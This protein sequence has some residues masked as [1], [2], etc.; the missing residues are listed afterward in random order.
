[1]ANCTARTGNRY[2]TNTRGA[3]MRMIVTYS[4]PQE[5]GNELVKTGKIGEVLEKIVEDFSPEA[6]YFYLDDQ[7]RRA[8]VFVVNMDDP[9]DL[10]RHVE[11]LSIGLNVSVTARPAFSLEDMAGLGDVVGPV[12]Q[13][14]G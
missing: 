2:E 3:A 14:Y 9:L 8:G 6:T 7:G 13:R 12:V 5:T 11:P 10:P 4:I 1:M